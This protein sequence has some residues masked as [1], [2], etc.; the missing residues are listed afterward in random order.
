MRMFAGFYERIEGP[1]SYY[2]CLVK[3]LSQLAKH[4]GKPDL[5]GVPQAERQS[6]ENV[7]GFYQRA[8]G[9]ASYYFCLLKQLAQLGYR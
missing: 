8:E 5:S 2:N 6:I 1:A 9:P 4:D 3:Q 7:C